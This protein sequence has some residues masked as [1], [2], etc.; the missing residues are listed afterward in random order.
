MGTRRIRGRYLLDAELAAF[1][2]AV[3][4]R[5]HRNAVRDRALFS[6]LVNTGIR[7]SEALAI[8]RG[9]VSVT[10]SESTVR[11]HRLKARI[12]A[13]ADTLVL[14][15][16]LASVI[17]D[18]LSE[19][20]PESSCKLFPMCQR[21]AQRVFHYY[22]RKAGIVRRTKLYI[23]RHTAATRMYRTTR[24]IALVQA[25]LGHRSPDTTAIYAHIPRSVLQ[26]TAAR[27]GA[28]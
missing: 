28:V 20:G 21:Q 19:L 2:D 14:T 9:D 18:R 15:H 16:G 13:P 11:V 6:L 27:V 12:D 26:E 1:M 8:T 5:E 22:A 17:S 4:S 24:D 10:K 23:L 3:R 25:M 7:P